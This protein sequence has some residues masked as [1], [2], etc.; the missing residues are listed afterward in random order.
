MS[1]LILF[2]VLLAILIA[3]GSLYPF[4]FSWYAF[5][6]SWV[7]ALLETWN[8]YASQGDTVRNILLFIPWG[9]AGLT[10]REA[11]AAEKK[12]IA[13]GLLI[14]GSVFAAIVQVLQVAVLVRTPSLTDL[15]LNMIGITVGLI[16][17]PVIG[18]FHK[19]G[20]PPRAPVTAV[21]LVALWL[22]SE[23]MPLVPTMEMQVWQDSLAPLLQNQRFN[24][25]EFVAIAASW[26]AVAALLETPRTA[27]W[28]PVVLIGLGTISI[29]MQIVVVSAIVTVNEVAA[30]V[31]A[32][33]LW[34]L[35]L[36]VSVERRRGLVAAGLL[37]GWIL[38]E[39]RPFFAAPW[40]NS[41]I[42]VPFAEY[43][44]GPIH[45]N[46]MNLMATVFPFAAFCLLLRWNRIPLIVSAII[47][48][49][50]TLLC[51]LAQ[52][53]LAGRTPGLTNAVLPYLVALALALLPNPG[54]TR[55]RAPGG[56][57][58]RP[59]SGANPGRI[60]C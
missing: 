41:F 58:D 28:M 44:G 50:T 27:R 25:A 49:A 17:W 55:R 43:L 16:L 47:L 8:V 11:S 2:V 12:R 45:I 56:S 33:G 53:H 24:H 59:T 5:N 3:A 39:L 57:E 1:R 48:S 29:G 20:A 60:R 46:L 19:D 10:V 51:E 26:L 13:I 40:P 35:L 15:W 14:S 54:Q 36:A 4:R 18:M 32:T 23:A 6:G 31:A 37:I 21:V 34:V 38:L 7:E 30:I 52:V 22:V 42:W 9:L